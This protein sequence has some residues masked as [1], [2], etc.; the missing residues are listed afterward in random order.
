MCHGCAK[1][2]KFKMKRRVL[3]TIAALVPCILQAQQR[4]TLEDCRQ[5]AVNYNRELGQSAIE[6]EI[7]SNDRGIARANYFP[8]VSARAAYLYNNQDIN[9]IG[10]ETSE[11][12]RNGGTLIQGQISGKMNELTQAI[13][14]N[15]ATAQEYMKSPMWQTVL[16]A[17]SQTDVSGAINNIGSQ[18]DEALHLDIHNVYV[19]AVSVTQ[20]IYAGG[21]VIA[22]NRI[23][24]LA[25]QL[26]KE[27]YDTKYQEVIISVDQ[28]YWQIVAIAAKRDLAES[29]AALLEKMTRDVNSLVAEGV[30]TESDLLSVKVKANEANG[31]L[32]KANNG[33]SL[34]KMLLCKQI[35]LPLDSAVIL[36]DEGEE[37]VP[38]PQML[39]SKP[40]EQVWADRPEIRSLNTAVEIYDNKVKVARADMLPTIAAT[41]NYLVTNPNL[42]NGFRNS[43]GGRFSGGVMV[44]IPIFH[45]YEAAF[46]TRKAKAEASLYRSKLEDAKE[47]ICLEVEK[48]S[49][50]QSEALESLLMAQSNMESAE[51]NLRTAMVGFEEGVVDANTAM[52]A[53]TA[54]LKAHS[55]YIESGIA[56]QMASANLQKAQGNI[57]KY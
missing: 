44:S 40:M 11:L 9:L 33:L 27:K 41:A 46:K 32:L 31:M 26:A 1:Q 2:M 18:L 5:M 34:A 23:A 42:N 43:F 24:A 21:K 51:E 55:E 13:M 12:L 22:A 37:Q 8:K 56:L 57:K 3:I 29:Y 36:E 10:G 16:G 25:E 14:S 17:L 39:E 47:M 20:P 19:G 6:I 28:S 49:N 53:Q 38:V 50:E 54:W 30:A 7:A 35:G 4:L 48:Y 52:S 45:G 15:P